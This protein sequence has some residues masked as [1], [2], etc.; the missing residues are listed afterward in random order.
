M[1]FWLATGS[2]TLGLSLWGTIAQCMEKPPTIATME[3]NLLMFWSKF[4]AQQNRTFTPPRVMVHA[5]EE[6]TSC[7]VV[8]F[9]HYCTG[10]NTIHLNWRVLSQIQQER[11]DGAMM[12]VLA[13]EY[14]H[15]V[16]Q[17]I[18]SLDKQESHFINGSARR[19]SSLKRKELQADCLAGIAFEFLGRTQKI[20]S[21]I[22]SDASR[23]AAFLGD[24]GT[25]TED[26]HGSPDQ[27]RQSFETG[28]R[29]ENACFF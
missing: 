18:G 15:A 6:K 2:L 20:P 29:N 17:S 24:E 7:A 4:F 19:R 14:G 12:F 25:S 16:Q 3:N 22:K 1:R 9:A 21:G 27:R 23:M 26:S 13:H 8:D 28:L 5:S 11:G 10:T